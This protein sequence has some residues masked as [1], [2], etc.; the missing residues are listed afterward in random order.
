MHT[1]VRLL[2]FV[3]GAAFATPVLAQNSPSLDCQRSFGF[4]VD[5]S[6]LIGDTICSSKAND[7]L[8]SIENFS[9]SNR[10]YTPTSSALMLGKFADVGIVLSY[11]ANSTRLNY[12]FVELGESGNFTGPTRIDSQDQFEDFVKN[13]DILGRMLRYQAQHSATSPITG[14]GGIITLAGMQ[15]FSTSFDTM[16]K[17]AALGAAGNNNLVGEGGNNNLIGVGLSYG[18]Y[19]VSGSADRIS[20]TSLPLSYTIRNDIDPRRQLVLSVPLTLVSTGGAKTVQ[21]SFGLAYRVP[22]SDNWTLTPG[23]RYGIVASKDRATLATVMSANLASTYAIPMNGYALAVGNMIGYYKTGKFSSGD[24]S[25]APDIALKMM[26]NGIMASMPTT[27]FGPKMAAEFSLIDM[28]YIGDKPFLDNTQEISFTVGTN[29][30][31][32]NARTF[33]RAGLSYLRGKNTQGLSVNL[34][35][36]F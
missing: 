35:Y 6:N 7:F 31:A 32:A 9:G 2:A 28:R 20:T 13:N 34:G 29:R 11:A 33:V 3:I 27:M 36:W 10:A 22:L 5:T 25:I 12:N 21:G 1:S 17:I 26:R 8:D 24:Y 18:N 4:R 15:D 23:A 14:V 16:S 19:S 30:N